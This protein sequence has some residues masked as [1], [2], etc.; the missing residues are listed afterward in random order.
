MAAIVIIPTGGL[1]YHLSL[2]GILSNID[3][4]SLLLQHLLKM[5]DET[6]N[7]GLTQYVFALAKK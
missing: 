6:I 2:N 5:D 4:E 1:I 7:M 3:E